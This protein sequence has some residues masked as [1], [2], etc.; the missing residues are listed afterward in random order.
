[1]QIRICPKC[2]ENNP[3][4]NIVCQKCRMDLSFVPVKVM[5]DKEELNRIRLYKICPTCKRQVEISDEKEKIK[6]CPFCGNDAIKKLTADSVVKEEVMADD[7]KELQK[8]PERILVRL[9]NKADGKEVNIYEGEHIIGAYGDCES[10]YFWNLK[11]VGGK[12][13]IINVSEEGVFITDNHSRN[14]TYINRKRIFPEKKMKIVSGDIITLADQN[15]EVEIC[16]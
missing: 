5:E 13:A 8:M 14:F 1:M 3:V 7:I 2:N 10:E 12:H 15:F 9:I 4:K 6:E 16:R 11:Y